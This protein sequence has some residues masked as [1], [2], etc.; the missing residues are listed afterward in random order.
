MRLPLHHMMARRLRPYCTLL[1]GV[2]HTPLEYKTLKLV[3]ETGDAMSNV[4][5]CETVTSDIQYQ[6]SDHTT[7]TLQDTS[8]VSLAENAPSML[9]LATI[10]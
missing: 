7:V 2:V 9:Q 10:G 6:A 1:R 3:R 8:F 4:S 5:S